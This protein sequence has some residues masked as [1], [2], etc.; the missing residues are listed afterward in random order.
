MLLSTAIVIA[1]ML[2]APKF[3]EGVRTADQYTGMTYSHYL[4]EYALE[5]E[6]AVKI[7]DQA[8]TEA[9]RSGATGSGS[10]VIAR[11][12]VTRAKAHAAYGQKIPVRRGQVSVCGSESNNWK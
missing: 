5:T 11:Q 8:K 4:D 3:C 1:H 6:N 12:M 2:V 9:V 10:E 7:F